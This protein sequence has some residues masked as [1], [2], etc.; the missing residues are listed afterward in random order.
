M[1]AAEIAN[2]TPRNA[3]IA[4]PFSRMNIG[5]PEITAP[6]TENEA[7]RTNSSE[8]AVGALPRTTRESTSIS[9]TLE[10]HAS[11]RITPT[12]NTRVARK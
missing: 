4:A 10:A 12:P 3:L 11:A 9:G 2:A 5:E 6:V 7:I 1:I 8:A